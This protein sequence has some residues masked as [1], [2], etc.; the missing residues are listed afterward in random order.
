[1]P[2]KSKMNQQAITPE[3]IDLTMTD[4]AQHELD[5]EFLRFLEQHAIINK[6]GYEYK[7]EEDKVW[8]HMKYTD[9]LNNIRAKYGLT[10]IQLS[11]STLER[12]EPE[13]LE[14]KPKRKRAKKQKAE[15]EPQ[16][17][18]TV[19]MVL[20]VE[21]NNDGK[22]CNSITHDSV[23]QEQLNKM[24]IELAK[25]TRTLNKIINIV[26]SLNSKL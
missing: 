25:A 12:I 21:P 7:S 6:C 13:P 14:E 4:K 24:M 1:M 22:D 9:T 18:N 2:R 3:V 19:N 17:D 26:S 15:A 23:S 5:M 10:P 16:P 20:N 8:F 11:K